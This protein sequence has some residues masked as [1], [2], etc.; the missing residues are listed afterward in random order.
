[1]YFWTLIIKLIFLSL[2]TT[3]ILGNFSLFYY[4]LICYG[5]SKLK[6]VDLIHIHLMAANTLIILS[7]G[8]PHT[9]AAFG[10]K[11]FLNDIQCRLILYIVRVGRSVSIGIT[12]LLSVFQAVTISQKESCCKDQK[13]K[14]AK[15][16]GC[17][18]SL[19]W[20][21][22]ILIHFIFLVNPLMKWY[23]NNVTSKRDFGHCSTAGR[24]GINDSLYAALVVCPE[25]CFSLL[26]A[27]S[28]G[29]MIVILYRHKQRV[30]HIRR[31]C[32]SS[33][34]SPESRATQNILALVSTFLAFYT[35]SAIL[36]GC[37][38][39]LSNSSWWLVNINRVTSL[40]F[41]CFGHFVLMNHYSMPSLS[42]VWIRNVNTLILQYV[43]DIILMSLT[44]GAVLVTEGEMKIA[45]LEGESGNQCDHT[46]PLVQ[47]PTILKK[48]VRVH[49]QIFLGDLTD[50]A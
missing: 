32:G 5:D 14:A 34:T 25:I 4:Y 16:I 47:N 45:A 38:A 43:N 26:M 46:L 36:Q 11:Q 39:L 3:G 41:P 8:V 15:Y 28:S 23:S 10:L 20:V 49:Y 24:D 6:T 29:S 31:P 44:P 9:M 40:C 18:L 50:E 17:T 19:L 33:R 2:T 7:K 48:K 22:Y 12:C 1:M 35:L 21:S 27:W 30:Q 42:L 37:V 13:F